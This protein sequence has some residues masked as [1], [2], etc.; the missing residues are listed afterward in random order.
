MDK[1]SKQD[2]KFFKRILI[3][4]G[5]L[6]G[7]LIYLHFNKNLSYSKYERVEF[8]SSG[9]TLYANLFYPSKNLDFQ[10][11]RPLI[12]Y[13][14]GLGSQR[15]FDLRIPL[16]LTKRGFYVAAL[17]Y[18]GHGESG[19]S[20]T[21]INPETYMNR[22]NV[23]SLAQDCSK[24]LDKLE[25]LPFYANVNTSQIGLIGHS[26]GGM[27]VLMNQALD[28]RFNVTVAWAPL[29]NF[30]P[31]ELGIFDTSDYNKYIPVNL[32]NITNT[33]NLLIIMHEDDE[34]LDFEEQ[35]GVISAKNLTGCEVFPIAHPLIGGGHQLLDDVVII[36]SINWFEE[37][38]FGSETINGP[39]IITFM[40]NYIVIFFTLGLLFL[41]SLLLISYSAKFFAKD[42]QNKDAKE[43][44]NMADKLFKP[45]LEGKLSKPKIVIRVIKIIFFLAA[46]ILNWE[47][48]ER[49]FG[50]PGIFLASLNIILFFGIVESAIYLKNYK[51]DIGKINLKDLITTQV[52]LRTLV[53]LV[54][55]SI[56]FISIYFIFSFSPTHPIHAFIL[57]IS[58]VLITLTVITITFTVL[59]FRVYLKSTER[60]DIKTDFK[61]LFKFKIQYKYFLYSLVCSLYFIILYLIFSYSYPFAFMWPSNYINF[62][63]GS[64]TAFPIYFSIEILYRKVIYPQLN[65]I[66]T[67][68]TKSKVIIVL[69]TY[70][71]INLMSLTW[72]WI[73][74]PSVLYT[75]II[76]LIV[77]IQNTIIFQHTKSFGAV[78]LSSFTIIQLFFSAVI[79]NALGV[80][81]VLHLFVEI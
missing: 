31:Q 19:G 21:D 62:I 28:P 65:F 66:K 61:N 34:L 8:Q 33:H 58:I 81:A 27:V 47:I 25:T 42:N 51:K 40:V 52:S 2:I 75:Y 74:F 45:N 48:F 13:C 30:D 54:I 53:L 46:F 44:K 50:L 55:Y 60:K 64:V 23:P 14:H 39:I 67:E 69:A 38:F 80:G 37:Y 16:E 76:F 22:T 6:T 41:I 32:L 7:L 10:E 4:I 15:D 17:D 57:P 3:L 36:K 12:I 78:I 1:I 5:L 73:F 63:L 77:V 29:V 9:S 68:E 11:N 72:S 56:Y 18:H 26:L 35:T 59:G 43:T 70:V 49:I 20:I 71:L 79:S 24:L